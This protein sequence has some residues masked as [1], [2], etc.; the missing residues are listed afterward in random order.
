MPWL[1]TNWKWVLAAFLALAFIGSLNGPNDTEPAAAAVAPSADADVAVVRNQ[2]DVPF[3]ITSHS[4]GDVVTTDR[5]TVGGT[6]PPGSEVVYEIPLWPDESVTASA[7]GT[8]SVA[9]KL[10]SERNELSFR[11][12]DDESTRLEL[13]LV[14]RE[15]LRTASPTSTEKATPEPTQ[16]P[17]AEPTP[18]ATPVPTRQPTPKPT[19]R[20][21]PAPTPNANLADFTAHVLGATGTLVADMEAITDASGDA[22][23]QGVID[24]AIDL[25]IHAGEEVTWAEANPP[26]ACYASVHAEWL[27][28]MRLYEEAGDVISDG[29]IYMDLDLVEQGVAAMQAGAE[30]LDRATT[31]IE[32]VSCS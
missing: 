18:R 19:P 32:S 4:T 13:V 28:A 1:R 17:T 2:L 12:G 30:A 5:V 25:W 14:V 27:A 11:V 9:L 22:D 6:A 16:K 8:W 20:P 15:T 7:E 26:D 29:W 3:E 23:I 21:T 31:A 24:A 10:R